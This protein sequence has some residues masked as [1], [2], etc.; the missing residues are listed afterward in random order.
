MTW[1]GVFRLAAGQSS[2]LSYTQSFNYDSLNR[3]ASAT[4]TSGGNTNWS[5]T[6][7]YDRYGNRWIDLGGGNQSLYFTV[8]TNR[9][10]GGS[11]DA[12]GNLL[13]DGVHTYTYDAENRIKKVDGA[14]A[15]VYDGAG[16]RVRKLVGENTRF[17]YGIGGQLLMEYDGSSGVV[18]KEYV[19]GGGTMATIA[20]NAK[21]SVSVQYLTSDHLGTPRVI[22]KANGTVAARHDYQPFG[23][24]IFA[25]TGG[26]TTGMGYNGSDGNRQKFTGYERDNETGL[27]FAQARY[28]S[29]TQ[30][31]FTSPDSLLGSIGNPQSLNR[32]AYVN[33]NP[34]NFT[35]PTGHAMISA[36]TNSSPNDNGTSQFGYPDYVGGATSD[37]VAQGVAGYET[38]LRN[39]RDAIAANAAQARGDLHTRDQIMAGNNSLDFEGSGSS[40]TASAEV[41]GVADQIIP[42]SEQNF[43]FADGVGNYTASDLSE[44][45]QMGVGEAGNSFTSGEVEA[46]IATAVNRQNINI[47][48]TA[49][50]KPRSFLGGTQIVGILDG[51]KGR[52]GGYDAYENRSGEA[53]LNGAKINGVLPSNSYACNQLLAARNFA[54]LTGDSSRESIKALYPYT[55]NLGV[56]IPTPKGATG[57]MTFGHTRV[58][59]GSN[60]KWP[61]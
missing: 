39:T 48:N 46:V 10:T 55:S 40:V 8:S 22:T 14:T 56:G 58:F 5:Q 36:M 33:N 19:Y 51:K 25:G 59:N 24:E 2:R 29:S 34:M 28:N 57:L 26:R 31:R 41:T 1:A 20:P 27:D 45:S 60:V 54:K 6:N 4:E 44:L 15:Y 47:A 52:G 7:G 43:D 13:N 12:A 53:K 18:K 42:C 32:Y 9:I 16:Q 11:Y 3:L 17:V 30:G 35:D 37:L 38:R 50:E 23:E 61:F 49:A 21:G